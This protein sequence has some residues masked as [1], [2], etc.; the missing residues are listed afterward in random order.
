MMSVLDREQS[1]LTD[2]VVMTKLNKSFNQLQVLKDI[3]LH[4]HP[5]ERVVI[6]GPSG[7]GKSTL[8]RCI[9][10]LGSFDSGEL[11]V[12]GQRLRPGSDHNALHGRVSMVFQN[13]NLFPHMT[14]L[15]NC[16]LAPRRVLG[17]SKQQAIERAMG[18][19]QRLGIES[20]ADKYSAQLS[21][22]QQQRA[23]ICR[24]LCMEPEILLFDEPTSALDPEKVKEVLIAMT[25]LADLGITMVCVTHELKFAR[26]VA[27]RVLFMDQGMIVES[28][29]PEQ[30]F[31]QPR[32]ERLKTF[33]NNVL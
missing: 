24:A 29:I 23:A 21:G 16:T 12:L 31:E 15:R 1:A 30:I 13:F 2:H 9:G 28:G 18:Y 5:R 4:I 14:I 25:E 27:D 7:S 17:L 6:C 11:Q 22:G 20:Q 32:T 10:G 33:L 3:D 19:L 8:I 26:Q